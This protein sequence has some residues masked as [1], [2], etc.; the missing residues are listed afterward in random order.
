MVALR[1]L[2][3]KELSVSTFQYQILVLPVG[4]V[5]QATVVMEKSV[6]VRLNYK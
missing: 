3:S 4:P 5:H 1:S 6:L 2:V